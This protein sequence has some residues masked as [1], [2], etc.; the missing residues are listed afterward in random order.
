MSKKKIKKT[1]ALRILDQHD[2]KYQLYEYDFSDE[3][4]D[5][6][7][8][9]KKIEK[10]P[11]EVFKTLVCKSDKE[12]YVFVIPVIYNLDLKKAAKAA[13]VKKVEMI[14]LKTLLPTTGYIHGGCSPIGMKKEFETF[15]HEDVI[16]FDKI[17][18]SAGL[19]G[20]QVEVSSSIVEEFGFKIADIV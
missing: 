8:V 6:M 5:G 4:I 15:F 19:R 1:N 2:I 10:N 3:H 20:L 12:Y 14:P 11:E 16:L 17:I 7:S 13:N 18:F 9:A